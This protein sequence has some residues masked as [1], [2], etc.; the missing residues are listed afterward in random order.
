MNTSDY[1]CLDT[2]PTTSNHLLNILWDKNCEMT[3]EELANATNHEFSTQWSKKEVKQFLSILIQLD[4]AQTK[5]HGLKI[6]YSALGY[7]EEM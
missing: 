1:I 3:L 7:G 6:Y 4:Y 5:R 2:L